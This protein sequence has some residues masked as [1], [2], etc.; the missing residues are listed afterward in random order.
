MLIIAAA[1]SEEI[2]ETLKIAD[3]ERH[4][5]HGGMHFFSGRLASRD[6]L[7][8]QTGVGPKKAGA[9]ANK[10]VKD[11]APQAVIAV[12]A[13]GATDPGLRVGDIVI[14]SAM[15]HHTGQQFP[16][17]AAW[18]EKITRQ[19]RALGMPVSRGDCYTAGTFI[20]TAG[21][22]QQLYQSTG[23]RVLDM[24]SASL[25]KR[26]HPQGVPFINIRII[27][28]TAGK[29]AFNIEAFYGQTKK[30]GRFGSCAYF[31]QNPGELLRAAQLKKNVR[32]VGKRIAAVLAHVVQES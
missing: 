25:A 8:V 31:L 14:A 21:Q 24:E 7:L 1:T 12:G 10:I 4:R 3:I 13:A 18:S 17:D 9:A 32:L 26:L 16:A 23:A 5:R 28:D 15:L 6:I 29:D 30:N 20:H 22:K 2:R 11:H 19:L 27:S